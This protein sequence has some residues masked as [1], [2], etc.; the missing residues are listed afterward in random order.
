M[1]AGAE[2][3]HSGTSSS[4]TQCRTTP[5]TSQP[6]RCLF[7]VLHPTV[8]YRWRH[9]RCHQPADDKTTSP[10]HYHNHCSHP[11]AP[12]AA[13]PA[14]TSFPLNLS[15]ITFTARSVNI[16]SSISVSATFYDIRPI[17]YQISFVLMSSH[18]PLLSWLTLVSYPINSAII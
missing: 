9:Y 4:M 18:W 8:L 5:I 6:P 14:Y 3:V 7:I 1:I 12:R 15:I 17:P 11:L 16:Q 13:A 10:S 2:G